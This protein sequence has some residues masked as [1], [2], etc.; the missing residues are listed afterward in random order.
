MYNNI[1]NRSI[2]AEYNNRKT[3]FRTQKQNIITEKGQ[4][5]I[6]AIANT[7]LRVR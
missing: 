1:C 7:G 2:S 4:Q 3:I 5:S 6:S